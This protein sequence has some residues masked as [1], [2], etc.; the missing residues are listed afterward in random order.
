MYAYIYILTLNYL[1][2]ILY[3]R[4]YSEEVNTKTL[5]LHLVKF[6]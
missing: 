5:E 2:Y 3:L 1:E 6:Y 4:P